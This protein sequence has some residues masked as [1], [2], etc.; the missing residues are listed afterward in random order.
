MTPSLIYPITH[1]TRQFITNLPTVDSAST[2]RV[3]VQTDTR[4]AS[5][6][7]FLI[8]PIKFPKHGKNF[9]TEIQHIKQTLINNNYSNNLVDQHIKS[10][11]N[12]KFTVTHLLIDKPNF[13]PVYYKAQY[14]SNYKTE[15]RI[16]KNIIK[17]NVKPTQNNSKHSIIVYYINPLHIVMCMITNTLA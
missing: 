9:Y 13:I 17:T 3:N 12:S 11:I 15:E 7:I 4:S 10:F 1:F 2:L 14:H 8:E 6:E 16:I 5:S